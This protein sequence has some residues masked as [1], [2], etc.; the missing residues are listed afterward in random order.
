[1]SQLASAFELLSTWPAVVRMEKG[2]EWLGLSVW[3]SVV[4]REKGVEWLGL[5]R[6]KG[7]GLGLG[8]VGADDRPS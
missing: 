6:E 4:R 8:V 3:G 1:M 7:E 5:C 2:V